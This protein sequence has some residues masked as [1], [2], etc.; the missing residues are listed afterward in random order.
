MCVCICI[1]VCVCARACVCL[2]IY[3]TLP[4]IGI[5]PLRCTV[6]PTVLCAAPYSPSGGQTD[7]SMH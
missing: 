1:Y 6:T 7:G 5:V 3:H 4:P 2:F